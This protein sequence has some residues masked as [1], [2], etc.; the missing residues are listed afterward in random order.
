MRCSSFLG[1]PS[2]FL[3]EAFGGLARLHGKERCGR[4]LKFISVEDPLLLKEIAKY[5]EGGDRARQS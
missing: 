1:S 3:E 2:S 5:I 4:R